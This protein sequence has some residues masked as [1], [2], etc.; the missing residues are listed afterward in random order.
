MR[1]RSSAHSSDMLH[2]DYAQ[3]KPRAKKRV[4]CSLA[5][6]QLYFSGASNRSQCPWESD[7]DWEGWPDRSHP[8]FL[9]SGSLCQ[10]SHLGC[11][12]HDCVDEGS[13]EKS[14]NLNVC[15]SQNG[16]F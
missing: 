4:R 7:P 10:R 16:H 12:K 14:L 3:P 11:G 9:L 15:H 6:V 13:F 8:T 1:L 5:W 2:C